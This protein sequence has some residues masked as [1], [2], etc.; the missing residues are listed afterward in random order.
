MG[1]HYFS[2]LGHGALLFYS[3]EVSEARFLEGIFFLT[4][5]KPL[6]IDGF[7]LDT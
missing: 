6:S 3:A 4:V 7:S 2:G 1:N 5:P